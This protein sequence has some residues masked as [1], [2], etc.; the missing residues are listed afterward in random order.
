VQLG[1]LSRLM[2]R[3]AEVKSL[4][5]TLRY[6]PGALR[7]EVAK[8]ASGTLGGLAILIGLHPSAWVGVPVGVATAMFAAYGWQQLRRRRVH[9]EVTQERLLAAEGERERELPWPALEAL[10]LN[11]YAFGR[12][13]QQGTLVLTLRGAGQRIKIDSAADEFATALCYAAQVARH[14]ELS[15]DPTTQANLEQLG[16]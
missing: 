1:L 10:K 6:V 3:P 15:L 8:G 14:R 9:I 7:W 13:A 2:G 5:V 4:P 12:K 11:Y 16:L